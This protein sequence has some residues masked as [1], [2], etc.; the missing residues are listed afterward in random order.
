MQNVIKLQNH[1][2]NEQILNFIAG[3][4]L[5]LSQMKFSS[6]VIEK[7][8]ETSQAPKQIADIFNGT[9]FWD[10]QMLMREL[11]PHS[12]DRNVRINYLVERLV[13]HLFGNYVLQR[14]IGIV[15]DTE[16]KNAILESILALND[17]LLQT[18]HGQKVMQKLAKQFP[19]IFR[20]ASP[21]KGCGPNQG[22]YKNKAKT[23]QKARKPVYRTPMKQ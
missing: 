13:T 6:N 18:N 10:D 23:P 2:L 14:V 5:R 16:L 11:G 4:F 8:L 12:R 22:Y 21:V 15:Q 17:Q 9:H 7:C 1:F 20:G 3:D 19:Q